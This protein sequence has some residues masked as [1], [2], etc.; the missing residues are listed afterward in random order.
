MCQMGDDRLQHFSILDVTKAYLLH[1]ILALLSCTNE[2]HAHCH[3]FITHPFNKSDILS[4][5][6][7]S[8]GA[9][10]NSLS[11]RPSPPLPVVRPPMP[12]AS[13]TCLCFSTVPWIESTALHLCPVPFI[14]PDNLDKQEEISDRVETTTI[15]I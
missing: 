1:V 11:T 15:L 8:V 6:C 13:F 9:C 4:L 14:V 7:S 12:L 5:T 3:T 2:A 10:I